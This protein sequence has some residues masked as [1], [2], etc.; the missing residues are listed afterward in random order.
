MNDTQIS[1]L[2]NWKLPPT[3]SGN[4]GGGVDL[5]LDNEFTENQVEA[6]LRWMDK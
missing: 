1:G 3:E 5:R 6:S 4:N 2:N